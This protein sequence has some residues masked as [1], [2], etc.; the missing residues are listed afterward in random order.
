[1]SDCGDS[2]AGKR[3]EDMTWFKT[4]EWGYD[5][6]TDRWPTVK[7]VEDNASWSWNLP[8]NLPSR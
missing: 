4:H 8:E 7:L 3:A 5:P 2:C 6:Q 1:M